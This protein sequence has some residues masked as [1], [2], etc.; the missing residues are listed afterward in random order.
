MYIKEANRAGN[1]VWEYNG[2]DY[3][4][5]AR[6]HHDYLKLPN[7]NVLLLMRGLMTQQ[8]AVAAGADS[9]LSPPGAWLYDFLLEVKP[10]GLNTGEVVWEWS[11]LD[12]LIQDHD[13]DKDNYG[14]IAGHPRRIDINYL[15]RQPSIWDEWD[16]D[17]T[18]S[19]AIDYDPVSDQIMISVRNYS[20]LWIIDHNTT[21]EEAAG[22]KGDLLYRWGNPRAYGA[23]DYQDQQLFWQHDTHWIPPSLPG[24]GNVLY[25]NNGNELPGLQRM[26]T[27]IEEITLPSYPNPPPVWSSQSF[28]SAQLQWAH[29]AHNPAD[30]YFPYGARAKRLTNG[31]TVI[32]K[33]GTVLQVIPD[34]TTVWKYISPV[35]ERNGPPVHQGDKVQTRAGCSLRPWYEPNYPGLKNIDLTPKG[36]IEHYR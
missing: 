18:H 28:A 1:I 5:F 11:I 6:I 32:C 2:W 20:E 19:N 21:T 34:G 13:P 3:K 23:G 33:G 7:G 9:R 22:T 31:N 30:L 24:E 35:P 26:Y 29:T 16:H 8:E 15:I 27:S 36:P 17:W 12:H 25:V 14:P 4:H 10:T